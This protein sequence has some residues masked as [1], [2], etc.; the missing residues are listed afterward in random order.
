MLYHIAL[1]DYRNHNN[2]SGHH[3]TTLPGF[4]DLTTHM[5]PTYL[6]DEANIH[7]F[8]T[9]YIFTHMYPYM[10]KLLKLSPLPQMFSTETTINNNCEY[11]R[12]IY[13]SSDKLKLFRIDTDTHSTETYYSI[14]H[15][16]GG[17]S[18]Y[19]KLFIYA[20]LS[21]EII[22]EHSYTNRTLLLNTDSMAIPL[23]PLLIPYFKLIFVADRRENYSNKKYIQTHKFTDVVSYLIKG[24]VFANK[25]LTNLQ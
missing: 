21:S 15:G 5:V 25:Y 22:N 14:C 1:F 4:I 7:H 16:T 9:E 6:K 20:H 19:H 17:Y 10:C 8:T 24:S 11:T 23:I 12:Y 3:Y 13:K 18:E 2:L